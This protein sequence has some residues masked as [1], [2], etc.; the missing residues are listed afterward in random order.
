[1]TDTA[2][3][4]IAPF[5]ERHDRRTRRGFIAMF[6]ISFILSAVIF[7]HGALATGAPGAVL[8][9]LWTPI[10]IA[11]LIIAGLWIASARSARKRP[12][13]IDGR[14]PTNPD[15]A[16]NVER[17]ANAGAVFVTGVCAIMIAVQAFEAL[18]VFGVLPSPGMDSGWGLRAVLM[19]V[20]ALM[21][22]FGNVWPRMPTARAPEQNPAAHMKYNRFAGW[23]WVIFGILLG[24][25][26]LVLPASAL[27]P[28]LAVLGLSLLALI[29]VG[30]VLFRIALKSQGAS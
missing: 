5:L 9:D 30:A 7:A 13:F 14:L 28:A 11:P 3:I 22:Y 26:A 2:P 10:V 24:L 25:A 27:T 6:F 21:L 19:G 8:S 1:M 15:D 20:A 18:S 4:D 29:V 12:A 16:R 17:V 23:L